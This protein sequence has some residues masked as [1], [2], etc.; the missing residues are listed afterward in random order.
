MSQLWTVPELLTSTATDLSD[1]GSAL[2]TANAATVAPTAELLPAAAD[3]ISTAIRSVFADH[4]RVY[5]ALSRQAAALHDQFVQ[6]LSAAAGSYAAAEAANA[7]PLQT[8]TDNLLGAVNAPT[9]ALL[10]RPLIGNGADG[11]AANPNGSAGGLLLGNGGNGFSSITAGVAGGAG[12]AA[13]LIGNGGLGGNGGPGAAGGAGGQGGYLYGNGGGGGIGGP[14][15]RIAGST[16]LNAGVGGAGGAAGMWG[17]GGAGGQGGSG[18]T[19]IHPLPAGASIRLSDFVLNGGTGGD[20]GRGGW[21]FGPG[22]A[23]GPGGPGSTGTAVLTVPGGPVTYTVAVLN[24]TTGVANVSFA[25]APGSILAV[26]ALGGT[27]APGASMATT[28]L[29]PAASTGG[30]VFVNSN[31]LGQP[32]HAGNAGAK[33][34]L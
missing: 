7:S 25:V 22:G 28:V 34:L 20:G 16:S 31:V 24:D 13:G 14:G 4:A 29:V 30:S 19:Y 10:G 17:A 23:A 18:G 6:A 5:Q 12:G 27:L 2:V 15:T 9:N 8:V 32:G 26:S 33:G 1:I 21:L 11:T 3:E